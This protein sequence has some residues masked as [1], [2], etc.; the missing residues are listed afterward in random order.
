[1]PAFGGASPSSVRGDGADL[2]EH[3]QRVV[4]HPLLSELAAL[5]LEPVVSWELTSL[6]EGGMSLNA[7]SW[8]R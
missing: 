5:N 2:L 4:D 6:P 1:M 7:P 3:P 8:G